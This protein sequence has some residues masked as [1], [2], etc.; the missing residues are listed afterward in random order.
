M[1]KADAITLLGGTPAT[2]ARAIGITQQALSQW[3]DIL[4]RR[5]QDRV[6]AA[7]ARKLLPPEAF[8]AP[9]NFHALTDTTREPEEV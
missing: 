5:L 2:A 4:P 9:S 8:L 1:N 3:P 6:E 7:I